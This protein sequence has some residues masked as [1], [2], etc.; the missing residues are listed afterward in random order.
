[1]SL[2]VYYFEISP[3]ERMC[4]LVSWPLSAESEVIISKQSPPLHSDLSSSY[5][6]ENELL[7]TFERVS[8]T[9]QGERRSFTVDNVNNPSWQAQL[10]GAK[11]W[12]LEPPPECIYECK[13]HQITVYPGEIS[14]PPQP[15]PPPALSPY[16]YHHHHTS[17]TT[18]TTT[19]T[20]TTLCTFFCI[21]T[22][23]DCISNSAVLIGFCRPINAIISKWSS[24]FIILQ[25]DAIV[26][27]FAVGGTN[28]PGKCDRLV[29]YLFTDGY[30]RRI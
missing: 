12:T 15:P 16:Q 14:P 6:D 2:A 5:S 26:P 28:N 24:P 20:T 18:A 30:W 25:S 3:H 19:T 27:T 9:L 4:T 29:Q 8:P 17:T 1:M 7:D 10:V 22:T 13:G 11:N 21:P 23:F